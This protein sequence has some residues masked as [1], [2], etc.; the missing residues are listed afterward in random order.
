MKI[1][2]IIIAI[3]FMIISFFIVLGA[4]VSLKNNVELCDDDFIIK[5]MYKVVNRM[6]ILIILLIVFSTTLIWCK[7]K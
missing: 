7:F 1:F 4:Y 5:E 3:I 6:S 2:F